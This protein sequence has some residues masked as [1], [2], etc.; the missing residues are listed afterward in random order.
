MQILAMSG[1]LRAT[2]TIG[3]FLRATAKLAPPGMAFTFYNGLDDVPHF[4]PDR[5]S[6]PPPAAVAHLR[7]LLQAADGVLLCTPEYAYGIPGAFK[8]ALDWTVSSGEF[9]GKP[10]AALGA[11]PHFMGGQRAHAALLLVLTALSANIVEGGTL[12]VSLVRTKMDADGNITDPDTAH[13]LRAVLDALRAG[14]GG[15]RT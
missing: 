12:T 8:N 15:C 13:A 2:S 11:S 4:A 7:G 1:S 6:D 10:V 14:A 3:M 5:D 9:V